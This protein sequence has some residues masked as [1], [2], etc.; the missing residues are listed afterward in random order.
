MYNKHTMLHEIR[1]LA[2]AKVNIGL[3]VSPKRSDGFHTIYSI[4]TSIPLYDDLIISSLE[5]NDVCKV[6]CKFL[7][8]DGDFEVALPEKNTLTATYRAFCELTGVNFGI[9]VSIQK[10]IP[11]GGGL[12]GGSSDAASLIYALEQ[13]SGVSLKMSERYLIAEKVGSDVFFFLHCWEKKYC[14]AFVTGRGE[15]VKEFEPRTDL[16]FVVLCP[17]LHSSTK[18]AYA[19]IDEWYQRGKIRDVKLKNESDFVQM[20]NS[21]VSDWHFSNTFTSV[22]I[23]KYPIIEEAILDLKKA[24]ALYADMSGSGASVFGVFQDKEKCKVSLEKLRAKWNCYARLS[25]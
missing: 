15:V 12:G 21:A 7:S 16:C 18:E 25:F 23:E 19:A 24:G 22:L 1:V 10:R 3:T 8:D 9:H 13:L 17:K 4:F 14:S 6:Q 2:P 5:E 11:M 20:Y